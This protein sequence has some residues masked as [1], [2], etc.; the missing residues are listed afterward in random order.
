MKSIRFFCHGC[1]KDGECAPE[2]VQVISTPGAGSMYRATCRRCGAVTV[3]PCTDERTVELLVQ[4]GAFRVFVVAPKIERGT[5]PAIGVDEVIDF[6]QQI[7][8]ASTE[9]LWADLC[10][11]AR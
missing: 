9:V 3:K 1:D 10:G 4:A 7:G 2:D 8:R 11:G 5:G 6:V